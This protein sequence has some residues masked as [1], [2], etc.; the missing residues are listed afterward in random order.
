MDSKCIR[1]VLGDVAPEKWGVT[2]MED[3]IFYDGSVEGDR[4]RA[5]LPEYPFPVEAE[6]LISLEN[7]G[8]LHRNYVLSRDAVSQ[9]EPEV[10]LEEVLEFRRVGGQAILDLAGI[11][12]RT[13]PEQVRRI[14][15]E[16]GVQIV[17]ATGYH[18]RESW[19]AQLAGS[20]ADALRD[21]LLEEIAGGIAGTDVIPGHIAV[22]L[23][24]LGRDEQNALAAAGRAARET[25]LSLTVGRSNPTQEQD[26]VVTKILSREGLA[27]DRVILGGIPFTQRPSF[28]EAIRNPKALRVD[29]TRARRLLDQG[30]TLSHSFRNTQ[31]LEL[32]GDYDWGDWP[33]L[34]GLVQLI[35]A[36][37]ARQLVLGNDC[38]GKIALHRFGGEG[39]CRMLY[40]T[41]P[42]LRDVAGIS[43]HALHHMLVGNPARLLTCPKS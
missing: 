34:S 21:R 31:M 2:S 1:T 42:T 8:M 19:P 38:R 16:T 33:E 35:A 5:A 4:L 41:V 6:D 9:T 37:Y 28:G 17:A 20:D 10:L 32:L 18:T 24:D 12:V 11:G 43:E 22:M 13:D 39:Y 30:F 36:G 40:F 23:S 7:V 15:R 27:P 3:Y 25:G 14:S 29:I 26:D